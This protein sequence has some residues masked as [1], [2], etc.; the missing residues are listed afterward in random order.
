[1]TT[2]AR[3]SPRP[4]APPAP[5]GPEVETLSREALRIVVERLREKLSE[6]GLELFYMLF[7]EEQSTEEVCAIAG[8]T[9]DAVYAWRSRLARLARQ[10]AV[11]ILS[12]SESS[13]RILARRPAS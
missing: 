13:P 5:A 9:A 8:L 2:S 11:D 1:M 12:E 3:T 10:I 7:V 4:R 6:R